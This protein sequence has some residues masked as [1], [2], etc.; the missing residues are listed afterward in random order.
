MSMNS[1][2]TTISLQPAAGHGR[3]SSGFQMP[4]RSGLPSGVR[5]AG[6]A[7]FTAPPFVRGTLAVGYFTH[8]ALSGNPIA[9]TTVAAQNTRLMFRNSRR[10]PAFHEDTKD[11]RR[12]RGSLSKA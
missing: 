7:R 3:L 8:C 6:A 9:I 11:T 4:D 5:G 12:T 10:T 1:W 2:L